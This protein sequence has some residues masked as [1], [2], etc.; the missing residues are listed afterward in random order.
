MPKL[1]T[2]LSEYLTDV[3]MSSPEAEKAEGLFSEYIKQAWPVALPGRDYLHNWHIDLLCEYLELVAEKKLTRLIINM[4]RRYGKSYLVSVFW[5]T[6]L[7]INKPFMRFLFASYSAGLAEGA[8]VERRALMQSPWY[9]NNWGKRFNLLVDQNIKT[10]YTNNWRGHMI[11]TSVGG[12]AT[13][14]GGDVVVVDDLLSPDLAFSDTERA[15]SNR[16]FDETLA[17]CLDNK[18]Q[19]A[20]VVIMQRL[21]T[22]DLTARL[23]ERGGWT[24]VKLAAEAEEDEII[25]FPKSGRI[26]TRKKGDLLWPRYEGKKEIEEHKG[27]QYA[28]ACQYQQRPVPLGGGLIKEE[29]IIWYSNPP[30]ELSWHGGI[31]TAT[32]KKSSAHNS[33]FC[34]LGR[35]RDGFLYVDKVFSGKYSV[36][37]LADL[38]SDRQKL[39]KFSCI[40][41]EL[42]NAGEAIKQRMDEAGRESGAYP[43]LKGAQALTDK[44]AR[45]MPV[46]YLIQNGTILFNQN[47]ASVKALVHKLLTFVPGDDCDEIDAFVWAVNAAEKKEPRIRWL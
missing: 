21:H 30:E 25:T 35:A 13:G 43:P 46:T 18:K 26:V 19:G 1:L 31:D 5:P 39:R 47:D 12:T 22:D 42:N 17:F 36:K 16:F 27:R 10:A 40:Q 28:F 38:V 6:W 29:W 34:E 44:T 45:L 32:S 33:A 24:L 37:Y 23:M 14:R 8:S 11:T 7:W 4:P 3:G 41:L 15:A 2:D 9:Q 20:F